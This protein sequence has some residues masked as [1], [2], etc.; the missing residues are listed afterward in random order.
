MRTRLVTAQA[1]VVSL[2]RALDDDETFLHALY[3]D[4]RAPELE[5]AGW[6]PDEGRAFVDMQF[7][8]QQAGYGAT[9]PEADHWILCRDQNPIG[10]LLVDRRPSEVRVVDV[11]VHSRHRGLGIGTVLMQEVMSDA[12]AENR[13][14]RLT[15]IAHDQRVVGWYERLGFVPGELRDPYLG[16]SWRPAI[17]DGA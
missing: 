14:V 2:R 8:A 12:A 11:V 7:R 3:A 4:R 13:P 9:F 15:V 5:A 10:R 17:G 1:T 6:G 16:M